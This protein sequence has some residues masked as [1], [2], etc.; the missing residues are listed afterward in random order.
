ME[1]VI[2]D[3]NDVIAWS[4]ELVSTT[5]EALPINTE[6]TLPIEQRPYRHSRAE[7]SIIELEL[8]KWL[9]QGIIEP[10]CS[11]W[12]SPVVLVPKKAIDPTDPAEPKRH[13]LCIDFRKL[14]AVTKTDSFPLPIMQDALDGL[15]KSKFFSIIDLRSAL[16]QL[17]LNEADKEKTAF[18]TKSGLYQ[19]TTLPFGLKN[20]P[21]NFQRLMHRVLASLLRKICM[22]YLDDIIV[23]SEDYEALVQDVTQVL[24]RLRN[25]S[26]KIH[27]EKTTLATDRVIYLGHQCTSEGILP[28]EIQR[29]F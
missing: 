8:Q 17:P 25:Y 27:S 12:S 22:V 7:D 15:G 4:E 10:S 11:P 21:S 26:L 24:T 14:N 19:F 1:Q 13:R 9:L 20:S 6:D 3:F 28:F 16:L 29:R 5:V 2:C 18:T 23:F